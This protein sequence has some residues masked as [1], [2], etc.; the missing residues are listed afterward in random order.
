MGDI[1]LNLFFGF[2]GILTA[3]AI[4]IFSPYYINILEKERRKIVLKTALKY[5]INKNFLECQEKKAFIHD[6]I[7]ILNAGD[8]DETPAIHGY[9]HYTAYDAFMV[10][11]YLME[12]DSRIQELIEEIYD[13]YHTV[14]HFLV[15]DRDLM[16]FFEGNL[17][18]LNKIRIFEELVIAVDRVEPLII[19]FDTIFDVNK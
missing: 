13:E 16:T 5:E 7:P 6:A 1:D 14:S 12:E 4:A 9:L 11:G 10:S 19:E 3:V 8:D 15:T 18:R 17:L 2:L